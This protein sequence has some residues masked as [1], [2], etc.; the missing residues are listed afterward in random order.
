MV[1][2][3]KNATVIIK[4]HQF[5]D[6]ICEINAGA[7]YAAGITQYLSGWGAYP[8]HEAEK[9]QALLDAAEGKEV[10]MKVADGRVERLKLQLAQAEEERKSLVAI[11]EDARAKKEMALRERLDTEART[12]VL[13]KKKLQEQKEA[14]MLLI[15]EQEV[16]DDALSDI[17]SAL[18]ERGEEEVV[19]EDFRSGQDSDE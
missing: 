9:R 14:A 15:A 11:R 19:S 8:I 17:T 6:G 7:D 4:G 5:V 16:A 18:E 13:V 1:G 12:Q 10:S 2:H 3:F